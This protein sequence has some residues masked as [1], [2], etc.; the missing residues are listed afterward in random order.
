MVHNSFVVLDGFGGVVEVRRSS[1]LLV[2][3]PRA[4]V[5]PKQVE[6][7]VQRRV[8]SWKVG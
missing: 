4:V 2:G 8:P 1:G 3:D 7:S 6:R 5:E